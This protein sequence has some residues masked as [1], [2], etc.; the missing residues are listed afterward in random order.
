M[1]KRGTKRALESGEE[2]PLRSDELRPPDELPQKE[3]A[4]VEA[5]LERWQVLRQK[6]ETLRPTLE[7]EDRLMQDILDRGLGSEDRKTLR[8]LA[9]GGSRDGRDALTEAAQVAE[10]VGSERH[11]L[12]E[13]LMQNHRELLELSTTTTP[14]N[15]KELLAEM[16]VVLD[17]LKKAQDAVHA[18]LLGAKDRADMSAVRACGRS[19]N[20]LKTLT[21]RLDGERRSLTKNSALAALLVTVCRRILPVRHIDPKDLRGIL[22][23]Y[24]GYLQILDFYF[25]SDASLYCFGEHFS[26]PNWFTRLKRNVAILSVFDSEGKN[27]YN[28]FA[29]SG[30]F[31]TPGAPIAAESGPLQSIEAEDEHGRVFDRRHDAEFKLL[32][33]LCEM[34]PEKDRA[35]WS[36]LATLWSKKPLCRSCAGAVRQ[37]EAKFPKLRLKIEVGDPNGDSSNSTLAPGAAAAVRAAENGTAAE[38]A[39]SIGDS[40]S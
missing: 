20:D 23:S 6:V 39:A 18:E 38:V 16:D 7:H 29:V 15:K 36:A 28:S 31:K 19:L 40:N 9:S 32:T 13:I 24:E 10:S 25:F 5:A 33:G 30:E 21:R 27:L 8:K 26:G 4:A 34:V 37:V 3:V 12:Q 1:G 17:E 35:E 14:D 2:V 11:R 22:P